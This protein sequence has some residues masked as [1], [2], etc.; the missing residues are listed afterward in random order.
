M[1]IRYGTLTDYTYC[2]KQ[3][4]HLVNQSDSD[5]LNKF[6]AHVSPSKISNMYD[7]RRDILAAGALDPAD[8]QTQKIIGPDLYEIPTQYGILFYPTDVQ[9]INNVIRTDN[10]Y[11]LLPQTPYFPVVCD[12]YVSKKIILNYEYF[13][14]NANPPKSTSMAL[15]CIIGYAINIIAPDN[16]HNFRKQLNHDRIFIE[17]WFDKVR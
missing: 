16:P 3:H 4:E 13:L 1:K 12:D 11:R 10:I 6:Y 9:F 17:R 2:I 8:P 14:D 7:L 5:A 15:T